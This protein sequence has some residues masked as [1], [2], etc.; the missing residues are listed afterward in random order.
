MAPSRARRQQSWCKQLK[1][2][3]RKE[4]GNA[5]QETSQGK[6]CKTLHKIPATAS[7]LRATPLCLDTESAED[8]ESSCGGLVERER[9][10]EPVTSDENLLAQMETPKTKRHLSR[11]NKKIL[12]QQKAKEEEPCNDSD[13]T[14]FEP[15]TLQRSPSKYTQKAREA[16]TPAAA[17]PH[18]EVLHIDDLSKTGQTEDKPESQ[19]LFHSLPVLFSDPDNDSTCNETKVKKRT[20]DSVEEENRQSQVEPDDLHHVKTVEVEETPSLSGDNRAEPLAS[21]TS[22]ELEF[23]ERNRGANSSHVDPIV[24]PQ[25]DKHLESDVTMEDSVCSVSCKVETGGK[26]KKKRIR[27]DED[28]EQLQSSTAGAETQMKKKKRKKEE[29]IVDAEEREEEEASGNG[30]EN[31]ATS[32]ET[33]SSYV[34]RKKHKKKQQFS[35]HAA[36]GGEE[37]GEVS[38]S[39]DALT[40]DESTVV[41]LKK[42]KKKKAFFEGLDDSH[43]LEESKKDED[44]HNTQQ[45]KDGLEDQTAE[46]VTKKKKKKNK[47]RSGRNISEDSVAQSDD[48]VSVRKKEKKRTSSFLVADA[49]ENDAQTHSE[50]KSPSHSVDARVRGAE[51]SAVSAGDLETESAEIT[52]KLEESSDGVRKKK[53]KRKR[54]TSAQQDSTEKDHEQD[55]EEMD[56]TCQ[57]ALSQLLTPME[58]VESAADVGN[59]ATEE[60]VASKKKKKKKREEETC[61]VMLDPQSAAEYTESEKS[62]LNTCSSVSRK[63]KGKHLTFSSDAKGKHGHSADVSHDGTSDQD[64]K[65][66][67]NVAE[68]ASQSPQTPGNQALNDI[69][70]KRKKMKS[71]GKILLEGKMSSKSAELEPRENKK[72]QRSKQSA[73][74]SSSPVLSQT[75]LSSKMSSS[76]R[77]MK[78]KHLIVKRTLYNPSGDFFTDD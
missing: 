30:V 64:N 36:Q 33:Q 42:K 75:S 73:V 63:K 39:N 17:E 35:N 52:G 8:G 40:L 58:K 23:N 28:V 3:K 20:H 44:E 71:P 16:S 70:D 54:K 21:Q 14:V 46:L 41:L 72:K 55:F 27:S 48:S 68:Q 18:T 69:R 61:R 19:N 26:K 59:S 29:T 78:N 31:T 15:Q 24:R 10:N 65:E 38:F 45:T 22:D 2:E 67:L 13:A 47:M 43:T 9:I 51:K 77:V 34:K 5:R 1:Q 32:E 25:V 12:F 76:D 7:I 6:Q 50:Q 74:I 49:E 11:E 60:D 62:S 53:R 56:K 37:G 4:A 57:S 66:T